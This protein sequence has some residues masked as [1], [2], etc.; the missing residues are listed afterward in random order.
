MASSVAS[1]I[2]KV[3]GN[4]VSSSENRLK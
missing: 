3:T 2:I 1:L 4:R